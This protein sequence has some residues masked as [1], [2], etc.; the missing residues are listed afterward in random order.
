MAEWL[1][2]CA[3]DSIYDIILSSN[4]R[5]ADSVSH[6][7]ISVTI[8]NAL[9]FKEKWKIQCAALQTIEW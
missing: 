8:C 9:L 4:P 7:L 3:R 6:T 1:E 5:S 2:G